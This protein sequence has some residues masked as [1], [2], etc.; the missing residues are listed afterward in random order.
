[1]RGFTSCYIW[2]C[3]PLKGEDYILYCHPEIQKT[4]QPVKL[5]EWYLTM[6]RKATAESIVVEVS[7]LYDT[8]FVQIGECRALPS[9]ARLPYFDG[10]YWP[11]AMEDELQKLLEER[12]EEKAGGKGPKKAK[13]SKASSKRGGGG[14]RDEDLGTPAS[15]D[16]QLMSKLG[17]TILQMKE[18]FIMV[19][20]HYCC[21]HCKNFIITGNRWVCLH[22]HC[23]HFSICDSCFKQE[24]RRSPV[25]RHPVLLKEAHQLAPRPIDPLV[26]METKDPDE[27]VE[28][29][30]FDTRQ[31]FLSLCQGNHY[32]YDTLRRAK[33][34]S[35]MVLY[36]LH[37]PTAPAF[38][39]TC[40]ACQR[41]IENRQ[42]WRCEQCPDYDVCAQCKD[43]C[44]HPHPLVSH[45]SQPDRN[46][47]SQEG[48]Q[49]R[50][51]EVRKML[52]LLAHAASCRPQPGTVCTY[53]K[54]SMVKMLFRH[55]TICTVRSAGGCQ[56][57]KR[58]WGLL[59]LHARSCKDSL[60]KV[61]R[62]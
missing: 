41:D 18:D 11:G 17:S 35:L 58:M 12:E 57:C 53:P 2:A 59:H 14:G 36:H 55:G 24:E 34:S 4:P 13:K 27:V 46:A 5:R 6:L 43:T 19:H 37:N 8:F 32:Q 42:G 7:N 51:K 25:D 60:C 3:P 23:K 56:H 16:K 52:E 28:S 33:H 61:P 30:F 40:N 62:C 10:D 47:Q 9:A 1:M 39:V 21:S 26:P 49:Q 48:R 29:E 20:M 22:P 44:G 31:A 50:I 54:C 45:A 15:L 38:V